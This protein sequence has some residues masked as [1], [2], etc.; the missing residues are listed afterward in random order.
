MKCQSRVPYYIVSYSGSNNNNNNVGGDD[1]D[2]DGDNNSSI[3]DRRTEN[4]IPP[5]YWRGS[6]LRRGQCETRKSRSPSRFISARRASFVR[7]FR[8]LAGPG[9]RPGGRPGER[10]GVARGRDRPLPLSLSPPIETK[11]ASDLSKLRVIILSLPPPPPCSSPSSNV[12]RANDVDD[13]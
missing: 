7:R 6:R 1:D 3:M 4:L 11:V 10:C 13:E 8:W 5:Y 2:G 12:P 9:W